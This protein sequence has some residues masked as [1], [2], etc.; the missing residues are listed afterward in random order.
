MERTRTRSL[1][2]RLLSGVSALATAAALMPQMP[3]LKAAAATTYDL[4]IDGTAVTDDNKSD[5]KGD[6]VFSYNPSTYTL[7]VSGDYAASSNSNIISS[8]ITNLKINVESDS[9]LTQSNSYSAI[10][11]TSATIS[12]DGRLTVNQESSSSGYSAIR[13]S[14]DLTVKD[15]DLDL[16]SKAG[17]AIFSSSS[18]NRLT[19]EN[20][21]VHATAGSGSSAIYYFTGGVTL[22][23]CDVIEPDDCTLASGTSQTSGGGKVSELTI[24]TKYPLKI[25]TTEVTP[26]NRDDILGDGAFRYL[27]DSKTLIVAGDLETSAIG[28]FSSVNGLTIDVQSYAELRTNGNHGIRLYGDTTIT[29][30]CSLGVVTDDIGIY[31]SNGKTLRIA[32]LDLYVDAGTYGICGDPN[33]EAL[34]VRNSSIRVD[35]TSEAVSDF[36]S[37]TLLGSTLRDSGM[38]VGHADSTYYIHES[39]DTETKAQHVQI[40]RGNVEAFDVWVSGVRV[41]Q[42][43]KTDVLGNG[44][45][46]YDNADRWL[47]VKGNYASYQD[48]IYS[49][50]SDIEVICDAQSAVTLTGLNNANVI[51]V[52]TPLALSGSGSL[53][54]IS[55]NGAAILADNAPMTVKATT[56]SATG[57][58][59]GI[60]INSSTLTLEQATVTAAGGTQAIS[61]AGITLTD[62]YLAAPTDG[63]CENGT[64]KNGDG[65]DAATAQFKPI[66]KYGVR[67]DGTEVTNLNYND[68]LGDGKFYY[69]GELYINGSYTASGNL[70]ETDH[71]LHVNVNDNAVLTSSNGNVFTCASG[72]I[73]SFIIA[74]G[75]K[76]TV[77]APKGTAV[78][79]CSFVNIYP[80]TMGGWCEMAVSG[81]EGFIGNS[82]GGFCV[83]GVTVTVNVTGTAA[84]SGFT[85]WINLYGCSITSGGTVQNGTVVGDD[86]TPA[87]SVI[88]YSPKRYLL[89]IAGTEVTEENCG[90]VLG[91]G[92]F[93]YNP[94]GNTLLILGN[95]T[96]TESEP[97]VINHIDGLKIMAVGDISLTN[98]RNYPVLYLS[99]DTE[100]TGT[101]TL[102]INAEHDDA[103]AVGSNTKLLIR[104]LTLNILSYDDGIDGAGSTSRLE[105]SNVNITFAVDNGAICDCGGGVTLTDCRIASPAGAVIDS[106]GSLSYSDAVIDNKKTLKADGV[107]LSKTEFAY[108]GSAVTVDNYL[109]VKYGDTVL[110]QGTD[111]SLSYL[112]NT[113]LG[114][115]SAYVLIKGEGDY[116][117]TVNKAFS[118]LPG[119][120]SE[121]VSGTTG[122]TVTFTVTPPT[123]GSYT[124]QWQMNSGSGWKN[125]GGDGATTAT[126][127]IPVTT[128]RNGNLYRCLLT[129][130]DSN[131][132]PSVPAVLL[133]KTAVTAQPASVTAPIGDIAKFTVTASGMSLS[134]Q[135]QYNKGDG[136]KTSN[137]TGSKTNTLSINVAAGYNAYKY[138]CVIT[139]AN[140][141]KTYSSAA[142]LKVKTAIKTQ[143]ASVTAAL[144]TTA[145]FTVS[146][147]GAGLTYQWQYNSG[148]GWKTSGGTGATTA[149]LSI[150]VTTGRNGF[151]Y[152]CVITDANGTK[153][154]SSA[155]TLKAKIAITAQPAG[156]TAPIGETA[157]FTVTATGAGLT[158]QWQYNKGAGWV[159]SNGT[160]SKTATLT[161]NTAAGYN[162]YQYRCIVTD[163]NGATAT[164]NA[165]TLKIKTVITTQ[166]NGYQ[167]AIGETAKFTVAATGAGLKYQWQYN[168]GDGWKNSGASGATTATLSINAKTTYN[169]WK[170]RC[171]ITDANGTATTSSIATLKIK[172]AIT[173]Q[174]AD[175]SAA[176]GGTAKFTVTATG[177]ELT[178]QWQYNAGDGWKNCGASGAATAAISISAKAAYNGWQ[179]RCVITDGNG[180]KAISDAA[181]LKIKAKI[182]TQPASVTASTGTV[183]KFTVAATGVGLSYQWQYNSGDGW[184]NSGASGAATATL[185]ISAKATYNGW[186]YRCIVTDENGNKVTS[187]AAKL[188]VK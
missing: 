90:D 75:K 111:Y 94:T 5:I 55:E 104:D 187:S 97:I 67:V 143:P 16:S 150:P 125:S 184:K 163:A 110:T 38:G 121:T 142:T 122:T 88:I 14:G 59:C 152:R 149:E 132:I 118:I 78:S 3:V 172:I 135:W 103:I 76:L 134:Y 156:I 42:L 49:T 128:G 170:Y 168:S 70:I 92:T 33:G 47:T 95:Y 137:G 80:K 167:A 180:K 12:G 158:Y 56:L 151:Q 159:N 28:I 26:D 19:V 140:G 62:T 106:Y 13:S 74:D 169:G 37:I 4:K 164:S 53:T 69:D 115:N 57:K 84:I 101:D 127:S 11:V 138:R 126:L 86:G 141:V 45:F 133:V 61:S 186:Q 41:N 161:I 175:I 73:F 23:G 40:D 109:T 22:T 100:L 105:L 89:T 185:S 83:D 18:G 153:T 71:S 130:S 2:T 188:T 81:K 148:D 182:T 31:I 79:S 60:Q 27:P 112:F 52:K 174:P 117:G 139:D 6:G 29:G 87:K 35:S 63:V 15:A 91:D 162:G 116:V 120:K 93:S 123:S 30:S 178:Y 36:G 176:I 44:I 99:A 108:T 165:A 32:D 146:A 77:K 144:G 179:Y 10:S 102:T 43:N 85:S 50:E 107:T 65:T 68:I 171:V 1:L 21:R 145:K 64:V 173:A 54:A 136:W 82:T 129:D 72:C 155:A 183:A 25:G 113:D 7:T 24:D 166:P 157:K 46:N 177:L 66:E 96:C 39:G 160:G 114:E 147:T 8:N 124:Y 34:I 154:N 51:E 48:V 20:S 9:V 98:T 58:S 119:Q 131:V 181:A 17:S